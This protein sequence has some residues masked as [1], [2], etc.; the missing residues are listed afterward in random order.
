MFHGCIRR[1]REESFD[2]RGCDKTA[3][4]QR[5]IERYIQIKRSFLIWKIKERAPKNLDPDL[6]KRTQL[7]CNVMPWWAPAV[8]EGSPSFLTTLALHWTLLILGL[9]CQSM[10]QCCKDSCVRSMNIRMVIIDKDAHISGIFLENIWKMIPW[11][12][13]ACMLSTGVQRQSWSLASSGSHT[14]LH[15]YTGATSSCIA[16]QPPQPS[17]QTNGGD[18]ED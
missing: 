13:S 3:L 10:T 7:T 9:A 6:I 1:D 18:D 4:L 15:I 11:F 2:R 8:T 14:N 12:F 16:K 5:I 17:K